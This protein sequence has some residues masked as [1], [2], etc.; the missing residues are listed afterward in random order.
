MKQCI[1][2]S[3]LT[4]AFVA[5]LEIDQVAGATAAV[6]GAIGVGAL[7]LGAG[8]HGAPR[9]RTLVNVLAL[10]TITLKTRRALALLARLG[11]VLSRE[12][13][14]EQHSHE[15]STYCPSTGSANLK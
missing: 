11:G 8:A 9:V 12:E 15:W 3:P 2:G 13:D 1:C 5:V 4:D 14:T 10:K 6:V 7:A